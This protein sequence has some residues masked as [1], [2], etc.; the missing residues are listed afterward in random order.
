MAVMGTYKIEENLNIS[1]SHGKN[2]FRG[3]FDSGTTS[4]NSND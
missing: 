1:E 3:Q 4:V 2:Y